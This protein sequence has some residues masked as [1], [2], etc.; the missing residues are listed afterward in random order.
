MN[1]EYIELK[2][3]NYKLTDNNL[4][5]LVENNII[6]IKYEK[7]T[8]FIHREDFQKHIQWERKFSEEHFTIKQFLTWSR[9][10]GTLNR[11]R[12]GF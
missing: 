3:L 8:A 7:K 10:T 9:K 6:G 12:N 1:Q 11:L 4:R 2:H 5:F